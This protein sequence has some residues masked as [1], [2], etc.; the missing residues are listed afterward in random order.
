MPAWNERR[1][2]D[3]RHPLAAGLRFAFR[4]AEGG[5]RHLQDSSLFGDHPAAYITPAWGWNSVM[6][7][8]VLTMQG[9]GTNYATVP[10]GA[11]FHSQSF[12]VA[13]LL[14]IGSLTAGL[15]HRLWNYYR[16]AGLYFAQEFIIGLADRGVT[17][18]WNNGSTFRRLSS[19]TLILTQNTEYWV[20]GCVSPGRQQIFKNGA[21]VG[22]NTLNDTISYP[23]P[24]IS[25]WINRYGH[26][27]TTNVAFDLAETLWWDR[28]ISAA[29]VAAYLSDV[30][31]PTTGGLWAEPRRF[32]PVAVAAGNS[33]P[34]LGGRV[35]HSI[36][37][38]V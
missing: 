4:G 25:P 20:V 35:N 17:V 5:G 8:P 1:R 22:T 19:S 29:D 3:T 15:T 23:A 18:G 11:K 32:V 16:P 21:S 7:R 14:K 34:T 12:T 31:D 28:A 38:G 37:M 24:P 36:G 9:S 33:I 27:E 30:T 10:N 13:S 26:G 6:G 2:L